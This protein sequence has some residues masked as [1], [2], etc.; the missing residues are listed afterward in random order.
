MTSVGLLADNDV[1]IALSQMDAIHD[2]LGAQGWQLSDVGSLA[3]MLRYMGKASEANRMRV[4]KTQAAADRFAAVLQKIVEIEPTKA[5]QELAAALMKAVLEAEL[6]MQGG[7]ITLI[8]VGVLRQRPDVA[9]GDKRAMRALP[10]LSAKITQVSRLRGRFICLEQ[11]VKALCKKF[12]LPRVRSA[13]SQARY[14]DATITAAYDAC[15]A[16]GESRF[17]ALMDAVVKDRIENYSP[18]WLKPI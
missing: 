1:V 2:A 11:I 18:G 13:V 9:T 5:E 16:G 4:M 7:E 10:M 15:G 6:D 14:A 12:G 3:V 17:M 8:A